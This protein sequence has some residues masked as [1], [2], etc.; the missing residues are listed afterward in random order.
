MGG[1]QRIRDTLLV[2][3]QHESEDTPKK[4]E[5]VPYP[6]CEQLAFEIEWINATGVNVAL[7]HGDVFR[8]PS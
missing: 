6:E 5:F 3:M 1:L 8:V 2:H 4:S 7:A